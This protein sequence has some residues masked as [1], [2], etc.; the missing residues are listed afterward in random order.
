MRTDPVQGGQMTDSDREVPEA[1]WLS[2][3][4]SSPFLIFELASS[5]FAISSQTAVKV[6]PYI[7]ITYVPGTPDHILGIIHIRGEIE[8]IVDLRRLFGMPVKEPGN[9]S[10][11]IILR[12][13]SLQTGIL[14]DHLEDI[15]SIPVSEISSV[16]PSLPEAITHLVQGEFLYAGRHV[17]IIDPDRLA[18][19]VL[20][21]QYDQR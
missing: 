12:T 17:M 14:V 13:D 15:I 19:Q 8:S 5:L 7:H 16:L 11:I 6:R 18:G 9:D 1:S 20:G 21:D 3:E 10:R 4:Q 2:E